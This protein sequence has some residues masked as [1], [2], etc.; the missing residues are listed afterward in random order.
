MTRAN[1]EVRAGGD[2]GHIDYSVFP[3]GL[4]HGAVA[5]FGRLQ[6]MA[7]TQ[8][9]DMVIASSFRSFDRPLLIWNEKAGGLRPL[10][11]SSG[12]P[13]AYDQLSPWELAQAILRWSALPGASRHH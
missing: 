9:F 2:S 5:A 4:H 6:E 10:Y 3:S 1:I 7:L 8:G 11:D 12:H 13:L